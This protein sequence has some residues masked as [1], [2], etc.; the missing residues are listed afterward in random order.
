MALGA[1]CRLCRREGVKL[2]LKGERCNMAKCPVE[3][4]RPIPGEHGYR[5]RKRSAYATQLREKQRLKRLYGLRERQFRK[6]VVIASKKK[7]VTGEVLLQF[8]ETRLDNIVYRLGLSPARSGARQMVNHGH[9]LVNGRKVDIPSCN[10]KQG[11]VVEVSGS[12]RS[13]HIAE[14]A[15]RVTEKKEI[16]SWLKLEREK[17]RGELVRV[18]TKDEIDVPVSLNLIIEFYSK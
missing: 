17:F 2:F 7:G 15:F 11:D 13:R 14:R 9:V 6:Y 18:P 3:R 16:P 10:L 1:S 5:R 8:L 12:P 4:Q